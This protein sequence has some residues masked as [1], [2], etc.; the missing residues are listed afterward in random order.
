M[1]D[2]RRGDLCPDCGA[3]LADGGRGGL[4]CLGVCRGWKVPPRVTGIGG[5]RRTR[6]RPVS[7][8]RRAENIQRREALHAAFGQYPDCTLCPEL[9]AHGITTGCNGKADDADEILRRSAGGSITDVANIRPV[10]RRCHDW[11]TA[12]PR[13]M[14][15]WGLEGSRYRLCPYCG[16]T[17]N[18]CQ[19][20]P[21]GCCPDCSNRTH[22]TGGAP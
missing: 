14:R 4:I 16:S 21:R 12:H 6:I 18:L 7:D 5:M 13:E 1:T 2:L 10:G 20:W 17:T 3:G 22:P 11:A 8:K 19:S 15:E 9:R